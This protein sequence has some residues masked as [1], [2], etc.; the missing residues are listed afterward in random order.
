MKQHLQQIDVIKGVAIVAVLLLHSLSRKELEQSYAI[1]HIWQAV[2]L[3]MVVMGL[4]LGLSLRGKTQRLQQLYTRKYFTK[5]AA[6]IFVPF[7]MVFLLSIVA[8][9]IWEWLQE[10]SVL[11]FN[12]YTWVGVFPVTGR[13]N[14]F[15]TLLLQSILLLPVIGYTFSRWPGLTTVG[16]VV[17]EVLFQLWAAQFSYFEENNYLYDAAFPRYFTA[18]A[19]GLWLS[20]LVWAP[21]RWRY[22]A[23]LATLAVVAAFCMYFLV[24][25]GLELKSLLRPEWQSQQLLTFGYAAFIVWLTIKL[26]PSFSNFI[27]LRLLAELGKASYHIF[28]IQVVY[29]G[30]ADQDLPLLLNLSVPI[31]LGYLFFKYEPTLLFGS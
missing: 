22:F 18:V 21:F 31:V 4:N 5:K 28:L 26:L 20:T 23:V 12:F 15:I 24:Y 3:F 9:L 1:Y 7:V 19:F 2:P 14:Y 30:L 17:L 13:G 16:L 27:P 11:E 10:E 25:Q 29:F 6:R 8:G